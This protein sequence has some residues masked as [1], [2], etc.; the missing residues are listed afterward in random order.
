MSKLF[1]PA[2]SFCLLLNYDFYNI[3][4]KVPEMGDYYTPR[5]VI[6]NNEVNNDYKQK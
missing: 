5:A 2:G 3:K 1:I 4:Y 6:T